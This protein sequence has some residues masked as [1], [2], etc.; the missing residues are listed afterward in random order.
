M[1]FVETDGII[2]I[3]KYQNTFVY[4]LLKQNEFSKIVKY[5]KEQKGVK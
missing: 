2:T 4:F 5:I 3:P 1:Q